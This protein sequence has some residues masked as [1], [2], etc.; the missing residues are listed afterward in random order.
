MTSQSTLG[1]FTTLILSLT[2][3]EARASNLALTSDGVVKSF[4]FARF[5]TDI[6]SARA[7]RNAGP[8]TRVSRIGPLGNAG[9]L[10]EF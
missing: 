9:P 3:S 6:L 10:A 7:S 8:G 1:Y 2:L 5:L 4:L